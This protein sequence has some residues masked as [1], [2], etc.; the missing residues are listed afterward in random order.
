MQSENTDQK[1]K[2]IVIVGGG[3]AG[4]LTAGLIAAKNKSPLVN[5]TLIE[6]DQVPRVGVGEGTWPSM[7]ETLKTLGI[8]ETEFLMT[9]DASFKQASKFVDWGHEPTAIEQHCYFHPFSLPQ[10]FHGKDPVNVFSEQGFTKQDFADNK[11]AA[12]FCTQWA[13][14]AQNLA[15]KQVSTPQ[16]QFIA[17]YGY[18]LDAGKF[19]QLLKNHCTQSLNVHHIVGHIDSVINHQNGHIQAVTLSDNQTITGDLFVDCSGSK[20]ILLGQHYQI[21]SQ[22]LKPILFNDSAIAVQV[23]YDTQQEI[24][25]NTVSTAQDVGWVWDIG[26]Q[27]RRGIGY[28]YASDYLDDTRA[29]QVLERYISETSKAC[30]TKLHYKKIQFSPGYRKTFWHKNCVAVGMAAGFIEPLEA[31]ALTLIEQSANMIAQYL[32][33]EHSVMA[34]VAKRFNQRL[35]Q[36]WQQIVEFLKLHYVL[37]KRDSDYW[38]ANRNE[39]TIPENLQDKLALWQQNAPSFYDI[40]LAAPLFPAASYQYVLYGMANNTYCSSQSYAKQSH[41]KQIHYQNQQ[42]LSPQLQAYLQE[43]QQKQTQ[44]SKHMPTNRALLSQVAEYGLSKI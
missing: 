29:Q 8:S 41:V 5:V 38:Q 1:I 16:Y 24:A 40:E 20:A 44:L 30:L 7:R 12:Q 22:S 15:P 25:S 34:V 14:C 19:A 3:S 13:V 35:T 18:H 37:S 23:P 42:N 2:N 32:P 31:S 4:W 6:S 11:F 36:H 17:N 33:V 21:E 39:A 9:C 10:P 28:V 43:I 27:S 26:L